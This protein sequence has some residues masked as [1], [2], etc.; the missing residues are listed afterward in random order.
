MGTNLLSW[1]AKKQAA[2]AHSTAKAEYQ[3]L[4]STIA[5]LMWYINLLKTIGYELP[6][7]SLHSNNISPL[8]M[9]KNPVFHHRTKYIEID[10]HFVWEQVA[11][12]LINFKHVSRHDQVADI[13]TKP[14]CS[15]Q[16]ESNQSKLCVGPIPP[17]AW[18]G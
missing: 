14:L 12:D 6:S 8:S 1:G 10:V 3:A 9:A 15:P 18:G 7:P 17:Q 4:E 2:V 11:W 13:F 16:F 5:E